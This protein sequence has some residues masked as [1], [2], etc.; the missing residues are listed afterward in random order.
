MV[1]QIIGLV[2]G[3]EWDEKAI[4]EK[5]EEECARM[6]RFQRSFLGMS[7]SAQHQD[8]DPKRYA[9]H[10]LKQGSLEERREFLG[11]LKTRIVL[12][13]KNISL[14]PVARE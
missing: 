6:Q 14:S 3:L 7:A 2:D 1:S 5:F 12:T 13:R 8:F 4:R 9:V 10:V 11:F